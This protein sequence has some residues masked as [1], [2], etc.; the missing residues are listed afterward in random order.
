MNNESLIISRIFSS[1]QSGLA[2]LKKDEGLF[3]RINVFPVADADTGTNMLLTAEGL[4]T[5][6]DTSSLSG[7]LDNLSTKA[8]LSAR[9]NSGTILASFI[10]GLIESIQNSDFSNFSIHALAESI[11]RGAEKRIQPWQTQR[12]APCSL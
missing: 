5:D 1:L 9:G 6:V 4:I 7:F 11:N 2:A 3:N 12:R 8:L 10:T